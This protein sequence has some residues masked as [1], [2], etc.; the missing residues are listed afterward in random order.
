MTTLRVDFI[1]YSTSDVTIAVKTG[2]E[3]VYRELLTTTPATTPDEEKGN[4]FGPGSFTLVVPAGR[5]FG[6]KTNAQVSISNPSPQLVNVF[7]GSGKDPWPQPPP[8]PPTALS[9][10]TDYTTRYKYFNTVEAIPGT[11]RPIPYTLAPLP[12]P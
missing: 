8:P 4:T 3:I 1:N 12:A 5:F 9:G 11:Y 10:A 7:S 2:D 6:F